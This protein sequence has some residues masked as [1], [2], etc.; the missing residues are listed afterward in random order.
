MKHHTKI[1]HFLSPCFGSTAGTKS[2]LRTCK[3]KSEAQKGWVP[4][5]DSYSEQPGQPQ[6]LLVQSTVLLCI[7]FKCICGNIS[8]IFKIISLPSSGLELPILACKEFPMNSKHVSGTFYGRQMP[9]MCISLIS[10]AHSSAWVS[11]AWKAALTLC[12]RPRSWGFKQ[13]SS[14]LGARVSAKWPGF[15]PSFWTCFIAEHNL[16]ESQ[17]SHLKKSDNYTSVPHRDSVKFKL[18]MFAK[19]CVSAKNY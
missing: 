5:S 16:Y 12:A 4:A 19:C 11:T 9:Q 14:R 1:Q 17:F 6:V 10:L 2:K 15:P 13:Y 7:N 8:W 3:K 18:I